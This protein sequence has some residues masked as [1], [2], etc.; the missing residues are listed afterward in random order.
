MGLRRPLSPGTVVQNSV[1][2]EVPSVVVASD[3]RSGSSVDVR[4]T[5]D[6]GTGDASGVAP[7]R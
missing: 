2:A 6:V 1:V 3:D 4:T 5:G 7:T